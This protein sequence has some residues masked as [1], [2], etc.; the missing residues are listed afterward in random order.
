MK[1]KLKIIDAKFGD[2]SSKNFLYYLDYYLDN[3]CKYK[4]EYKKDY[5]IEEIV[6]IKDGDLCFDE[7]KIISNHNI[8]FYLNDENFHN[9]L[10]DIIKEL[11]KSFH[12]EYKII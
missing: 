7:Q 5:T 3:K 10:I 9:E 8:I 4:Y 1:T 6:S 12:F 11:K 2:V